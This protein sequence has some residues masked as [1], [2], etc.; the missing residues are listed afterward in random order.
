MRFTVLSSVA[1]TFAATAIAIPTPGALTQEGST[2]GALNDQVETPN[3]AVAK[4]HIDS[5]EPRDGI[6]PLEPRAK[7]TLTIPK[8]LQ[9]GRSFK[10]NEV[11]EAMELGECAMKEASVTAGT[12]LSSWHSSLTT[13]TQDKNMHFTIKPTA[14][15]GMSKGQIHVQKTGAWTQ[16]A[17]GKKASGTGETCKPVATA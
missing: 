16:G 14:G 13:N 12:V 17:G 11:A 9:T 10:Q 5:L 3:S 1:L 6:L 8:T 7:V 2:R 15:D 4:L